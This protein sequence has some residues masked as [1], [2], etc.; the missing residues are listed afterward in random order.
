MAI[1]SMDVKKQKERSHS[2]DLQSR[3]CGL[4][5]KN[6]F[7]KEGNRRDS[8]MYHVFIIISILSTPSFLYVFIY[9][10]FEDIPD[11]Y[12]L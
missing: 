1:G 9:G 7:Y 4:S 11:T 3:E 6:N 12:H 2:T 5:K 8:Y 10:L